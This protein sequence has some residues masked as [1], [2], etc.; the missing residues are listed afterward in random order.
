MKVTKDWTAIS[1]DT[2]GRMPRKQDQPLRYIYMSGHF[3][4]RDRTEKPKILSD[5]NLLEAGYLRVRI[6]HQ[7]L[8]NSVPGYTN[9]LSRVR[10]NISFWLMLSGRMEQL[11]LRL[12]S[13]AS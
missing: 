9:C 11:K 12:P 4:P 5:N 13:P 7:P 8:P 2:L 6:T 10:P 3:A 1:L